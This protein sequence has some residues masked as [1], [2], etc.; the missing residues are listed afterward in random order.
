MPSMMPGSDQCAVSIYQE[1]RCCHSCLGSSLCTLLQDDNFPY[2]HWQQER[3]TRNSIWCPYVNYSCPFL[4]DRKLMWLGWA[5]ARLHAHSWQEENFYYM[6]LGRVRQ[7]P[8]YTPNNGSQSYHHKD[9][10]G[11][12]ALWISKDEETHCCPDVWLVP[13]PQAGSFISFIVM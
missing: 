6:C 12:L 8:H 10:K 1:N 11:W 3:L 5:I 13:G 2:C 7:D 9:L 4:C